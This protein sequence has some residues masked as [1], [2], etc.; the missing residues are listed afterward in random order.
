MFFGGTGTTSSAIEWGMSE[1]LRNPD[2]M[3]KLQDEATVKEIL[4]TSPCLPNAAS[5]ELH[6]RYQ[7]HG[8]CSA[9][10]H[11]DIRECMGNPQGSSLMVRPAFF[12]GPDIDYKGQHFELLP[13]GSRRRACIGLALGHR[14]VSLTL[15]S[16][17]Q[18]FDW[19]VI[20]PQTLDMRE[21]V[22]A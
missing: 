3:K 9:Q 12:L 19:K 21:K 22:L 5:Q 15:A 7:V 6:A 17:L 16:L 8:L 18:A 1:L 2:S 4:L 11:T 13:F 14:M 10:K 20:S